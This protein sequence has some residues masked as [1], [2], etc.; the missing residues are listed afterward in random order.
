MVRKEEMRMVEDMLRE[1]LE[2]KMRMK[3]KPFS[4]TRCVVE[5]SIIGKVTFYLMSRST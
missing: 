3:K 5:A 1:E 2:E 4:Y